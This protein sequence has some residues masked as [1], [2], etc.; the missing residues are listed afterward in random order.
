MN[1]RIF[2][3]L[4]G[5][6]FFTAPLQ[7]QTRHIIQ[8]RHKG[9][10]SLSL[11]SPETFL[12]PRALAR[13]SRQNIPVDSADL[14]IPTAYLDSIRNAGAVTI[15]NTSHWLNRVAIQTS[16]AN[17]LN[18]INSFTFVQSVGA[19]AARNSTEAT[20]NKFSIEEELNDPLLNELPQNDLVN[21]YNY[22]QS[23]N[24]VHLH[25]GEF[26]HNYGFSG[27]GMQLAVLDAGFRNYETLP[28][29]DS[30]RINGQLL[31]NWDFV[32]NTSL[33]PSTGATH[34]HGTHCLS[35]MAANLP[36][37][38]VGTAPKTSFYLYRTENAATEMPIEEQNIAAALERADSLGADMASVSLG[39]NTFDAP[40][41]DHTYAEMDGNTTVAARAADLAAQKGMLVVVANGNEGATAWHY[42]TTPAD[43]DSVLAVGAVSSTGAIGSFSSY[44]P[45]SD[46]QVK[47]D[48]AA[49][50]VNAVVAN[51]SSGQPA[52][53]SGTSF[54]CPNMAGLASCLWQAYPE[55]NNMGI[56]TALRESATK[57]TTPDDRVGYGIP[58]MKKAFVILLKRLYSQQIQQAG[59]KTQLRWTAK[60]SNHM[61][62]EVQ[63]KLPTDADFISLQTITGT[64]AFSSNNQSYDDD[65]T[66]L[67]TPVSIQYR[68]KMN[69]DTD[70][71]FYFPTVTINHTNTCNTYT[72]TGN[73]NWSI[74][75]NWVGNNIP[76]A[77]LPAGS[78]IFIDPA[79][80]GECILNISQQIAA[81]ALI[82]VRAGKKLL[83]PGNL[84]IQ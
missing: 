27:Q 5:I 42:L 32:T 84:I 60:S 4:T 28:T 34:S 69:M 9:A 67:P 51:A 45:S 41:P 59:C 54:A 78:T 82:E 75:S 58:D 43:A 36:G 72:F 2:L 66:A 35:T 73:G 15:L 33:E 30:M 50:G 76:P 77:I 39:Y 40:Y 22:G 20:G 7:A 79:G 23:Y 83:V 31:G 13:R 80:A 48:V 29:F 3:L 81:G 53:S 11:A 17:A 47:P 25:Q 49:L 57:Y 8:L 21:I 74:A 44:G 10:T 62:F 24:Q 70:T 56:I 12:T 52:F 68:I 16:D 63:R 1:K 64:G 71:S 65:L 26:L 18:T 6:I 38:F 55:I 19:I 14:P 37:S 61:S 46:G